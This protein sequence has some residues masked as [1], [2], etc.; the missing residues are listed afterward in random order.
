MESPLNGSLIVNGKSRGE[1]IPSWGHG[2]R[3]QQ[4]PSS[5]PSSPASSRCDPASCAHRWVM[6]R[7]CDI[8]VLRREEGLEEMSQP[9]LS[10]FYRLSFCI[11]ISVSG[12]TVLPGRPS[13]GEPGKRVFISAKHI[14]ISHSNRIL[15][16]K[17]SWVGL[18]EAVA[19]GCALMGIREPNGACFIS[20]NQWSSAVLFSQFHSYL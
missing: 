4:G 9:S 2:T 19:A 16:V 17:E 3:C 10:P 8:C 5:S 6:E 14:V 13:A 11:C 1:A 20:I 18:R 12:R 15:C 7:Q